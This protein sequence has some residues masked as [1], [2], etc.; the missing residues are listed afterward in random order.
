MNRR[1][2]SRQ[3]DGR[4][5]ADLRSDRGGDRELDHRWQPARGEPGALDDRTGRVPSHQSGHRRQGRQSAGG[6]RRALQEAGYRHVRL[7]RLAGQAAP[8]PTRPVRRPVP[9]PSARGSAE[10]GTVPRRSQRHDRHLGEYSMSAVVNARGITKQY[11]HSS[12][13]AVDDVSFSLR[14][15]TIYGL[16]G[17]NGAGK[18]TLMQLLTGQVIPSAGTVEV[19]GGQPYEN[20]DVLRE[21]C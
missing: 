14:E 16:L 12:N 20:E 18:T 5:P 6:R 4:G 15:N 21:V 17:R 19:L 7:S 2:G 8:P 3:A 9:T 13:P 10:V 1:T 11:A